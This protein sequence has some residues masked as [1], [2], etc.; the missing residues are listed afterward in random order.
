MTSY[1]QYSGSKAPALSPLEGAQQ[2]DVVIVGGG[3]TGL[4]AALN[5]ARD[6]RRPI[7]LEA[8]EIG[9]GASGRNGGFVSGKLRSSLRGI[10][11]SHGLDVAR[12]LFDLGHEAVEAVEEL[13]SEHAIADAN[14]RRCGYLVAAHTPRAFKELSSALAW[15]HG[16]LGADGSQLLEPALFAERAGTRAYH[17]GVD[18]PFGGCIHP[19]NYARGLARAAAGLGIGVHPNSPA[20]R[21]SEEPD[22]V[23]VETPKG[24]VTA[25]QIVYATN[26]YATGG[27]TGTPYDRSVVPF[28]SAV[29]ATEPLPPDV[30]ASIL[31]SGRM[32][33]DTKRVLRWCRVVGDRF[34]FGGRGSFGTDDAEIAYRR[35]EDNMHLVFPQTRDARISHRWSG[36][37]AMTLSYMPHMGQHDP[38][39]F[40]SMGYNGTGVAMAS[41]MG[42]YL[43]RR[44]RGEAVNLPLIENRLRPIPF[45]G[46]RAP[47][48]R[49]VT[50][51]YELLDRLGY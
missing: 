28:R 9:H 20:L 29:L 25:R 38:R 49:T 23:R 45:H 12:R 48:I 51:V 18:Y 43:A 14:Y 24:S 47:V 39:S 5:I 11:D 1:W 8:G 36:F 41:L 7:V 32:L 34:V 3:F 13:V 44:T 40:Y 17:G 2:C 27:V 10:A 19:L 26:A 16:A 46:L 22:G 6:G 50:G 35:I 15:Q 4:S 21:I 37:V 42:R 31:P 30:L 33:S